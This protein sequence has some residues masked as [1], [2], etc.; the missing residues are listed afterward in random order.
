MM[1]GW[2]ASTELVCRVAGADIARTKHL[3]VFDGVRARRVR[4]SSSSKKHSANHA[5]AY[6]GGTAVV[7]SPGTSSERWILMEDHLL[8]L[9][10]D[11]CDPTSLVMDARKLTCSTSSDARVVTLTAEMWARAPA[12]S[13]IVTTVYNPTSAFPGLSCFSCRLDRL[14]GVKAEDAEVD[15]GTYVAL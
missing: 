10:E 1:P 4:C 2:T 13:S 5:H 11:G 6:L 12:V 7:L 14:P 8:S 3:Y 9:L 15:L